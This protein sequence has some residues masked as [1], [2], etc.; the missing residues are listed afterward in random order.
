MKEAELFRSAV[1]F[2][3]AACPSQPSIVCLSMLKALQGAAGYEDVREGASVWLNPLMLAY[4]FFDLQSIFER[5]L[6]AASLSQT[7]SFPD[8]VEAIQ[9]ARGKTKIEERT[10]IPV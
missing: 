10:D 6:F 7:K 9:L 2:A 5:H 1:D 4:W 3:H 8:L